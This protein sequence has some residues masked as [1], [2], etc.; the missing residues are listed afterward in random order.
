MQEEE[1]LVGNH[2]D[3]HMH[4]TKRNKSEFIEV[5]KKNNVDK[6]VRRVIGKAQENDCCFDCNMLES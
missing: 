1:Y 6:I 3:P 5:V 2:R 4:L